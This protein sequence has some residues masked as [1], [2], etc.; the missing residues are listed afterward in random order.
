MSTELATV[1]RQ[2]REDHMSI[3]DQI[4]KLGK[5]ITAME[6]LEKDETCLRCGYVHREPA[7]KEKG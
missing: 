4:D 2:L 6:A 5:A 7:V 1:L 3:V